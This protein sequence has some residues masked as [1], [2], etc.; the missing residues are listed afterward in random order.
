MNHRVLSVA[1]AGLI[2]LSVAAWANDRS[3]R[4][5]WVAA[6]TA[7]PEASD[8]DPKEPLSNLDGQTVRER[9][10]IFIGG[11]AIRVRLSNEHGSSPLRIGSATVALAGDPSSVRLRSIKALTFGGS[12]AVTIPT[13]APVLSDPVAFS[14]AS[15]AEIS[16]SLYFPGRV[17]TPT[18][19]SMSLKRAIITPKGDF[20]HAEHLDTQGISE[21]S[22]AA[23][24]VLVPA[25]S[26]Q[27]L[28]IAFGDSLT[29]GDGSTIETDRNWPSDLARR[30]ANLR[31]GPPIAV[32]NQGIAGNRLLADGFAFHSFGSSA[33][34]RF[35]R[36]VLSVPGA[37][38]VVLLEGV[39]DLGFPGANIGRDLA[40]PLETVTADDLVGAYRQLIARAHA[41]HVRVIGA[42]LTP[43]E[44]AGIPGY[45]SQA[46]E[47][48]RQLVNQWIRTGGAFDGLIDFDALLR[49]PERP[50]RMQERYVSPDHLHPNDAGYQA[51]ADAIDLSL[52]F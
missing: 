5:G 38:H 46:K 11:S 30:V 9:V 41:A 52:L 39:N 3:D 27:R 26:G 20:T 6:W 48:T 43:F 40:D 4:Q 29:D 47:A 37:T 13:G 18:L 28:L 1:S 14:V 12:A 22:I 25:V 31:H 7:S 16:I 50:S 2:L 21:S 32:V 15:G 49:D 36:D 17:T 10:R 8:P 35:D 33:L 24:A 19:H 44:G 51:M 42:T 34:A 45:Y 23:S